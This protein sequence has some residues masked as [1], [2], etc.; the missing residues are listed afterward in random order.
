MQNQIRFKAFEVSCC[1]YRYKEFEVPHCDRQVFNEETGE[2][3]Y[4]DYS[5][6]S[7]LR[8]V[9][10]GRQ[11]NTSYISEMVKLGFDDILDARPGKTIYLANKDVDVVL[12]GIM[13]IGSEDNSYV[14]SIK[15]VMAL[16]R[17]VKFTVEEGGK[18][19]KTSLPSLMM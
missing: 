10:V 4:I 9:Q 13:Y 6:H 11:Y 12:V 5:G 16:D 1:N 7:L 3:I 8:S 2:T 18:Y 19:I 17:K 15:T 14:I